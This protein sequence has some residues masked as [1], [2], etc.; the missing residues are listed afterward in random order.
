[1]PVILALGRL[2]QE[3]L[4]FKANLGHTVKTCLKKGKR[5]RERKKRKKEGKEGRKGG[6]KGGRKG[7]RKE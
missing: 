7:R 5:K 4:E 6:K 2:R 1:L 3:N